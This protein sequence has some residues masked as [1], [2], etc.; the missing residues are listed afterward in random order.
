MGRCLAQDVR[1]DRDMPP[2]DRS[3]MDGYA[4]RASDLAAGE[5][6]LRL[7]GEVAA[8]EPAR[9]R[10]RPGAC[11]RILTG[12][13]L[14]PG[15]DT[16]VP[17]ESTSEDGPMVRILARERRGAHIRRRGEESRKGDVLVPRG[18]VLGAVQIGLCAA[19]GRSRVA[20]VP[21]PRVAVLCT[22]G[23]LRRAGDRV[24]AQETRDSN[25][26]ALLAALRGRGFAQ[27]THR[28]VPDDPE[29]T[30]R[31]LERALESCPLVAVTGGVSVGR[32]DFVPEALR[33]IGAAVRFHGVNMRP[34][35]PLLY[36]T[37]PG[38]RHV[39]GLPGNPLSVL[40]GFHE[41]VLPALRRLSGVAAE[42]CQAALWVRLAGE[43]LDGAPHVRCVLGRLN[44]RAGGPTATPLDFRGSADLA[45]AN[46]ADGVVIVPAGS[47]GVA[48]GESVE[49]RPWRALP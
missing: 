1:A 18:T 46:R 48:P 31:A 33:R 11:V 10:V 37:L 7:A 2:A 6:S 42:A 20:V 32:Y 5:C 8:G 41:F 47:S 21:L 35:R 36:A 16:V 44:W 49:F 38:N 26:P 24:R 40:T 25:G 43:R 34:G 39:F 23:E 19:A 12:A 13:S 17:V 3:A 15:A 30:A 4:V 27:V 22:G 9:I 29:A 14:P 28:L 45:A